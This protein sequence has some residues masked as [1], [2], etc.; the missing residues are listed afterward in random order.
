[1]SRNLSFIFWMNFILT[2]VELAKGDK[3]LKGLV[4]ELFAVDM[5]LVTSTERNT[6]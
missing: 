4:F 1:M 3:G 5:I 6:N 2:D